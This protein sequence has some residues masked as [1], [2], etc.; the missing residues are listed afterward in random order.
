MLESPVVA[1]ACIRSSADL[2]DGTVLANQ[3]V[4][5]APNLPD[6][7]DSSASR[8]ANNYPV[9]SRG[10]S[11]T[12]HQPCPQV[13]SDPQQP[14]INSESIESFTGAISSSSSLSTGQT[15]Q[16]K[17]NSSMPGPS[18]RRRKQTDVKEPAAKR[19]RIEPTFGPATSLSV[20]ALEPEPEPEPEPESVQ[21]RTNE[22]NA[23]NA[24]R[25][26]QQDFS[27]TMSSQS[28][29]ASSNIH[30]QLPPAPFQSLQAPLQGRRHAVRGQ[31]INA[32][33]MS[34]LVL[35]E[36]ACRNQDLVYLV[37]HQ[38]YCAETLKE[39]SNEKAHAWTK[40]LDVYLQ[41]SLPA[42]NKEQLE[43]FAAY[44]SKHM[45]ANACTTPANLTVLYSQVK[46]FLQKL[47]EHHSHLQESWF[48][49]QYPVLMDELMTILHLTS[50]TLQSVMFRASRKLVT[51]CLSDELPQVK[52]M[53]ALFEQDQA[54]H[55]AD[56][57]GW[58]AN[59]LS[60]MHHI[61][62]QNK[63]LIARYQVL[64]Q[65]V[66]ELVAARP[67][68]L[69]QVW[70]ASSSQ[71]PSSTQ[72]PGSG[73]VTPP[74]VN[75]PLGP[76]QPQYT[77][78]PVMATTA[79][80]RQVHPAYIQTSYRAGDHT[81][82]FSSSQ[83]SGSW[84]QQQRN[85][86]VHSQQQTPHNTIAAAEA[87]RQFILHQHQAMQIQRPNHQPQNG[88]TLQSQRQS[89]HASRQPIVSTP[90][91]SQHSRLVQFAPVSASTY[92]VQNLVSSVAPIQSQTFLSSSQVSHHVQS[93]A[94]QVDASL[95][96]P[97]ATVVRPAPQATT[98]GT[99]VTNQPLMEHVL[100]HQQ[101]QAQLP[102]HMRTRTPTTPQSQS[103]SL[104][105]PP[106]SHTTIRA[107]Q[108]PHDPYERAAIAASLHQVLVRSPNRVPA[109][110][111]TT[112]TRY[113]QFVKDFAVKPSPVSQRQGVVKLSFNL[114]TDQYNRI[115]GA[116][117]PKDTGVPFSYFE[118]GSLRY[119]IKMLPTK[120]PAPVST[121][122]WASR[123]AE[124][125]SQVT[126][127]V[128]TTFLEPRRK[129][130]HSRDIPIELEKSF[131]KVGSNELRVFVP[132]TAEISSNSVFQVAVEI[133]EIRTHDELMTWITRNQFLAAE[134][135]R[136]FIQQ[137]ISGVSIIDDEDISI[138]TND[139]SID[140]ADPW[141]AAIWKIPARGRTCTHLECFD[142]ETWL[143]SRPVKPC[144]HGKAPFLCP[145]G[146]PTTE[147]TLV[148]KW[149]CPNCDSDARPNNLIIDGF[150]MEIRDCLQR[151]DNLSCV[152][153]IWVSADGSWR[154]KAVDMNDSDDDDDDDHTTQA[155]KGISVRTRED[156]HQPEVIELG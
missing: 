146:C 84:Q 104:F 21:P 75:Y 69:P 23:T 138:V 103:A 14:V 78:S 93:P 96:F 102:P 16:L 132:P 79:S 143:T 48:T 41:K 110:I 66:L 1:V 59:T 123:D 58:K 98:D 44:P 142:L 137:R 115:V 122:L 70:M 28:M 57:G 87:Q 154:P 91:P 89:F 144:L 11:S 49:R 54:A 111:S 100:S 125:P 55:R 90:M 83:H 150:L 18:R 124:W 39:L 81:R 56:A 74:I 145:R 101:G 76:T 153:S 62:H 6:I 52:Q 82:F 156:L 34:R 20:T 60:S 27:P 10:G 119:R 9:D 68:S 13:S 113:Y 92:P 63:S 85:Q 7:V 50:G 2:K 35:L 73:P 30:I 109:K 72:A 147:P 112:S 65:Q 95:H 117:V 25:E 64:T 15:T 4:V 29:A 12:Q 37:I 19:R 108:I 131:L 24:V 114:T 151:Q 134:E 40:I 97:Q 135:S 88:I 42:L 45:L 38:W 36:V 32:L 139:L 77:A 46:S 107:D 141:S 106:A 126:L 140:L 121:S 26:L 155:A 33:F 17:P 51:R 118:S 31:P 120:G 22:A 43:F 128:N 5:N 61:E 3:T 53:D 130:Q 129:A 127:K 116:V 8:N 105:I 80:M 136:R 67:P 133:I 149:K 99:F 94:G 86:H 148:D 47:L 152:K 71:V